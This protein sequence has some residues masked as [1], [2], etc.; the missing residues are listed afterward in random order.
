MITSC[1]RQYGNSPGKI[2]AA[3]ALVCAYALRY[4]RE[5]VLYYGARRGGRAGARSLYLLLLSKL[6]ADG[7]PIKPVSKTALEYS[8]LFPS[9]KK[10]PDFAAFA[11][12]YTELRWRKFTDINE[13]KLKYSMLK[14]E[15]NNILKTRRRGFGRV[16]VSTFNL[17]GLAYL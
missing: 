3:A 14:F 15:Y 9:A 7:K 17:R 10:N 5:L 2:I 8:E 12:L 4:G 1:F 16:I 11:A 6:A 13:E